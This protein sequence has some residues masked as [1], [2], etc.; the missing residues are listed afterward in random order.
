[1]ILDEMVAKIGI[2]SNA[3]DDSREEY[4]S[5][6]SFDKVAAV[7]AMAEGSAMPSFEGSLL[8]QKE[9]LQ[10]EG[11]IG[12]TT[13]EDIPTDYSLGNDLASLSKEGGKAVVGSYYEYAAKPIVRL[14]QYLAD[15]L[16]IALTQLKVAEESA[17]SLIE[18]RDE[19][20]IYT[21]VLAEFQKEKDKHLNGG[22]TTVTQSILDAIKPPQEWLDIQ[23]EYASQ[24]VISNP[25]IVDAAFK[26]LIGNAGM[27][28]ASIYLGGALLIPAMYDQTVEQ[29]RAE[30]EK[31]GLEY[32]AAEHLGSNAMTATLLAAGEKMVAGVFF[33]AGGSA[34]KTFTSDYLER[35]AMSGGAG[36]TFAFIGKNLARLGLTTGTMAAYPAIS[37]LFT[38]AQLMETAKKEGRPLLEDQQQ[39]DAWKQK[40]FL[41]EIT[42]QEYDKAIPL[43]TEEETQ[44]KVKEGAAAGL[45]MGIAVNAVG[46]PG[47]I[48]EQAAISATRKVMFDV[49]EKPVADLIEKFKS[50][51][52]VFGA[53]TEERTEKEVKDILSN[54]EMPQLFSVARKLGFTENTESTGDIRSTLID[55]IY[56]NKEKLPEYRNMLDYNLIQDLDRS[57]LN[58]VSKQ[59]ALWLAQ[60]KIERGE[61]AHIF[62]IFDG[63]A[64]KSGYENVA[65]FIEK[66]DTFDKSITPEMVFDQIVGTRFQTELGQRL[67]EESKSKTREQLYKEYGAWKGRDG[68]WR[69]EIDPDAFVLQVGDKPIT[70]KKTLG[71]LVEDVPLFKLYPELTSIKIKFDPTIESK[72]GYVELPQMVYANEKSLPDPRNL[73]SNTEITIGTKQGID[74]ENL[75]STLTHEVQH[76]IQEIE[77]FQYGD[78]GDL[79]KNLK[80]KLRG[81]E[82]RAEERN[83]YG[84]IPG[85]IE[86]HLTEV[87]GKM[88][89][90]ERD[91]EPIWETERKMLEKE[92]ISFEQRVPVPKSIADFLATNDRTQAGDTFLMRA[93]QG[94]EYVLDRDNIHGEDIRQIDSLI[95][96]TKSKIPFEDR[97]ALKQTVREEKR[98]E[99]E[100]IAMERERVTAPIREELELSFGQEEKSKG[101]PASELS[102][103][104]R[105]TAEG[106]FILD[107]FKEGDIVT[108]AHELVH[109]MSPAMPKVAIDAMLEEYVGHTYKGNTQEERD[110]ILAKLKTTWT[111]FVDLDFTGINKDVE[112]GK[113][114]TGAQEYMARSFEEY[115]GRGRAPNKLLE[116]AFKKFAER[117]TEQYE[118]AREDKFSINPRIAAVFDNLIIGDTARHI[119]SLDTRERVVTIGGTKYK[120]ETSRPQEESRRTLI[121][122]LRRAYADID[123]IKGK[124][125]EYIDTALDK[126]SRKDPDLL[127]SMEKLDSA[128]AGFKII[129]SV[130]ELIWKEQNKEKHK[131]IYDI[132]NLVSRSSLSNLS[133]EASKAIKNMVKDINISKPNKNTLTA[134]QHLYDHLDK[135]LGGE[136]DK[137]IPITL[138]AIPPEEMRKLYTLNKK[139]IFSLSMDELSLLKDAISLVSDQDV[140]KQ[141][142]R[143]NAKIRG[144]DTQRQSILKEMGES[145]RFR[146]MK[147]KDIPIRESRL[148]SLAYKLPDYERARKIE[149]LSPFRFFESLG[150]PGI[151]D[152]SRR[153]EQGRNLEDNYRRIFRNK[154]S[155]IVNKEFINKTSATLGTSELIDI[156]VLRQ[157]E[158]GERGISKDSLTM[159][160]IGGKETF[161]KEGT[162]K[163]SKSEL[164]LYYGYTFNEH[165]TKGLLQG[166]IKV[167]ENPEILYHFRT[168][169]EMYTLFDKHLSAEQKNVVHR[170]MTE[171]YNDMVKTPLNKTSEKMYGNGIA[172]EDNY[173]PSS[174]EGIN[175][176]NSAVLSQDKMTDSGKAFVRRLTS[177]MGFLNARKDNYAPLWAQ[178]FYEA[179]GTNLHD[180]AF[181]LG[182]SEPLYDTRALLFSDKGEQG[183]YSTL[184]QAYGKDKMLSIETW[185]NKIEDPQNERDEV[186]SIVNRAH[187]RVKT[188]LLAA[189]FM[190]GIFQA[191]S[192][193]MSNNYG[194]SWATKQK[195]WGKDIITP[196]T[197][198]GAVPK[199]SIEYLSHLHPF[200]EERFSAPPDMDLR[201]SHKTSVGKN[202]WLP[203]T[204]GKVG[205]LSWMVW[206]D[207]RACSKILQEVQTQFPEMSKEAQIDKVIHIVRKTQASFDPL[208]SSMLLSTKNVWK[209]M[210]F[211][212]F[213][214]PIDAYRGELYQAKEG[215]LNEL[216]EKKEGYQG[217]ALTHAKAYINTALIA[218]FMEQTAREVY[219]MTLGG[220]SPPEDDKKK[221][222]WM[223]QLMARYIGNVV[224]MRALDGG[225]WQAAVNKASG[226]WGAE[227]PSILIFEKILETVDEGTKTLFAKEGNLEHAFNTAL[228]LGTLSGHGYENVWLQ[229]K[230]WVQEDKKS[231]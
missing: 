127:L 169:T 64:K 123:G 30:Y 24:N 101:S 13:G 137:A 18:G 15:G 170:V 32:N 4:D 90:A 195:I 70:E 192:I 209:K 176:G 173:L 45:T 159:K 224:G 78:R 1:M 167:K 103:Q 148:Q 35:M 14:S 59:T 198:L 184:T 97:E 27:I 161:F 154:L 144:L 146:Q 110:A 48:R 80:A 183:I 25:N 112:A 8:E 82:L 153:L 132:K 174:R 94:L 81:K 151:K 71:E 55:F 163:L 162:I 226:Q 227:P 66:K 73:V 135:N 114:L 95:D 187:Q 23:K 33:K 182:M 214:S 225:I 218:G 160:K 201:V 229:I 52:R 193:P 28:H 65:D 178:D 152:L 197:M 143:L 213:Q 216:A 20:P 119:P 41:G 102:G 87:R 117:F 113:L 207:A 17:S 62:L 34:L 172:I 134:L 131:V 44:A 228:K 85:E 84:S 3:K 47:S 7:K 149:A 58:F 126:K 105:F 10:K 124:V 96:D 147:T 16:N 57:N 125:Q 43:I 185:L 9:K 6:P 204:P 200:F 196:E 56:Q 133:S 215:I 189:K 199:Y 230:P 145:R 54:V 75:R 5:T 76:V 181:F 68:K 186:G 223:M 211:G 21:Q 79:P 40:M 180:T 89:R 50:D 221:E 108:L 2:D 86:S 115:V 11:V 222:K 128:K 212:L 93:K 26:A 206:N 203:S 175:R 72:N 177:D 142:L 120:L 29:N 22:N 42:Q 118:K 156:P 121:Q 164:M 191:I 37:D 63:I 166:G 39:I 179:V 61:I 100:R 171:I 202:M 165:T 46:L 219:K 158:S 53:I 150:I 205:G 136:G 77:R 98:I 88:T 99:E 141:T 116:P 122:Y 168:P 92:G 130:D 106:K 74:L 231:K 12:K 188:G 91:A 36:Q 139:D 111:K 210:L 157:I 194:I 140:L 51:C 208:F 38:N 217:R 67:Q 19:N 155:S 60:G 220:K 31:R 69:T 49:K 107:L 129:R 109:A 104:T 83:K 138:F 190:T